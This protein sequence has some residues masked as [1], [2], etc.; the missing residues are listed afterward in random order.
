MKVLKLFL[1][2]V[3]ATIL[4]ATLSR[5]TKVSGQAAT[6]APQN[7]DVTNGFEPQGDVNTPNTFLSDKAIFE[8]RD[9]VA[10]GLGP[11][12]NAQSCAE[13]HQN[14]ATGG[15]SQIFEMRAGHSG[16]DGKFVEAPG[17][18]LINDRAVNTKIQERV[19]DGARITYVNSSGQIS[20]M[21][22]DGGQYGP[23]GN[24]PKVGSFPAFSPDGKRLAFSS[25]G[26][27]WIT[28]NDLTNPNQMTIEGTNFEPTWSPDGH[29]LA[30]SQITGGVAQIIT[31][32]EFGQDQTNISNN[33]LVNDRQPSWSPD[34]TKIAFQRTPN[35]INP[36]SRIW[37]MNANGS[38]QMQ[39]TLGMTGN[40]E[41]PSYSPDSANITFS[42]NRDGNF[43]I[44]KIAAIGGLATRLT[45][46][47]ASD[48]YPTWSADNSAIAF[49]SN[50]DGSM[51]VW[52]IA[53]DGSTPTEL[54]PPGNGGGD[55]P[56]LS[57]PLRRR[58]RR[59]H[60]RPDTR[61][62]TRRPARRHA[63]HDHPRRHTRSS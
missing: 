21:G 10:D 34:G 36:M 20:V 52:A 14:R 48:R 55:L 50:R 30:F 60:T 57:Q 24:A 22:W 62:D 1:V 31:M 9:F 54:S 61:R 25:N 23:V 56:R 43:E 58:L 27:I 17:G 37:T 16:P 18:S 3:F 13:C 35:A 5:P 45:N 53:T 49:A 33:P 42:T 63:R 11:V 38:G 19:P 6:E 8:V 12:Y 32:T 29:M 26:D 2:A 46:N 41:R 7:F 40:D 4:L 28:N 44:Y 47:P 15:V 39:V 51:N 59:V